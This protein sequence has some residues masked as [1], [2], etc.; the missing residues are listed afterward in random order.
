MSTLTMAGYRR[1]RG[2]LIVR[3]VIASLLALVFLVPFYAMVKTALS[4][5]DEI[6]S[7]TFTFWPSNPQWARI[8]EVLSDPR[9]LDALK[10]SAIMAVVATSLSILI[11]ALA[12]YALARIPNRFARPMFM[13]VVIVLLI[14][15][16]TAFVP[17]FIIVASLGWIGT[18]RGLIIPGLFG[19][20]NVFLF[21][22]F[23]VNFPKEVEEAAHIDGAGYFRTFFQ[24][25]F[26]NTL[27]FASALTVLGLIG[28]WNAFLWPLVV[29]GSGQSAN[30]VQIYLSSF[31]TAQTFDYGGL[32]M[33]ATLSLIPVLAI[34]FFL[35]RY[36]VSGIA[37]TGLKG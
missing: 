1:R 12:G 33:A 15:G 25:I 23:Y 20:F 18:L 26:P 35:Q 3:Y 29:A 24:V 10:N 4:T 28:S 13:M 8:P 30:T 9:F 37:A 2:G 16:T 22:Q 5:N 27:P 19:A 6:Y 34:F 11:A 36:L 17:N 31:L 32:F 7:T 14:P 21:R